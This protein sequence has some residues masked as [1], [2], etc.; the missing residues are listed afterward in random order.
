MGDFFKISFALLVCYCKWAIYEIL[1]MKE[2]F[3]HSDLVVKKL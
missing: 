3:K 2:F 1:A